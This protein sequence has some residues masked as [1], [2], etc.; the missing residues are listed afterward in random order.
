MQNYSKSIKNATSPL[1][2]N[3]NRSALEAGTYI[4]HRVIYY[5][6]VI[7]II[8][9][10]LNSSIRPKKAKY[11]I[12]IMGIMTRVH[13]KSNNRERERGKKGGL[14]GRETG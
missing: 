12:Q 1:F 5:P 14:R 11:G 9:Y 2:R 13:N 3:H 10:F 4:T 8:H 6:L 7:I